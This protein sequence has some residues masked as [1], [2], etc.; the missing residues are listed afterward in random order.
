MVWTERSSLA[1]ELWR[2]GE[3]ELWKRVLTVSDRTMNRIG[4]RAEYH[5]I[6]GS[7][8]GA[9]DSMLIAKA[10]AL[11]AVEVLEGQPRPLRRTRRRPQSDF[12]GLPRARSW[13]S[14]RWFD[15]HATRARKTV[16]AARRA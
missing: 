10:L 3:D 1:V 6:H 9:G 11:G 8:T 13:I 12:P 7:T 5:L 15:R 4:E 16:K 2:Y 14:A